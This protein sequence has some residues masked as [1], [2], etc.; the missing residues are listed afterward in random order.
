VTGRSI[1]PTQLLCDCLHQD[2]SR[3]AKERLA[4]VTSEAWQSLLAIARVHRVNALLYHRLVS[5]GWAATLP[6]A[7]LAEAQRACRDVAAA[8][9]RLYEELAAVAAALQAREI[10]V[11]VLKGPHV[12][13]AVYGDP[14]LR[15]M[16][17]LDLLVQAR[18]LERAADVVRARGYSAQAPY[19]TGTILRTSH[20]LPPLVKAGVA[21]I[22]LHWNIVPPGLGCE[23]EPTE[24]WSRA[25]PARIAGVDVLG[26]GAD[27]LLLHLCL[28]ASYLH[29]FG[30]GLLPAC[31]IAETICRHRDTLDWRRI[32]ERARRWRAERGVYLALRL[33]NEL[34]G[35]AVPG[36][37]LDDLR[38]ATFDETL[39]T[40]ASAQILDG[41]QAS[42]VISRHVA[43]FSASARL[44]R[45]GG[46][47]LRRLFVSR[48]ELARLY[49]VAADSPWIYLYS[50]VRFK[51]LLARN[52]RIARALLRRDP[53]VVL[54][55]GRKARLATWLDASE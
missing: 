7:T 10:P 2:G 23:V 49:G 8:N 44:S 45:K 3:I 20:H 27:D 19:R 34:V 50:M 17:D 40:A 26:L 54:T 14:A 29:L 22:E 35:A 36:D 32:I 31:D 5:R 43:S 51:D 41:T 13:S 39:L 53:R 18:D 15:Q 42:E 47:V 25:T 52:W 1:D 12:A 24:L 11:I 37:V 9:L 55:A 4:S 48:L 30:V 33:A 21:T 46:I 38:P 28:H 6:P 16:A